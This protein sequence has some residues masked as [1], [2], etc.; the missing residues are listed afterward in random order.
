MQLYFVLDPATDPLVIRFLQEHLDDMHKASPPESVHALDV[1]KLRQPD[2]RFWTAWMQ[3]PDGPVL[4]GTCALKQLDATHAELKTMRVQGTYRGSD[5]AQRILAHALNEAQ[6]SGVERISLE[7]G[8]EP[9]FTPARKF[10]ARNGFEPCEPFEGYQLDP[11]SC[12]MT[13]AIR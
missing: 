4:V 13:R 9:F 3:Q 7:T 2:I 8:T 10:Y 11:H 6:A 5:A 1:E 12:F